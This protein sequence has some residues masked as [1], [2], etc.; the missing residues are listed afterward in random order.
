MVVFRVRGVPIRV[1]WSWLVI[2]ALVY[3]SL[4]TVLFPTSYE[5]LATWVYLVMAAVATVLL[6]AS[7]LVHEL[8]HTLQSLREGVRIKDITL[9]LFGGVSQADE[10]IP[11]PGAEFRIVAAGPAASAVLMVL[12]G[13]LAFAGNAAGLSDPSVGVLS[14]LARINGLLLV[15]NVIPALPL[16]GGRLLHALLWWRTGDHERATLLAAWSGRIF[17]IL[18]ISLGA[19]FLALGDTVG[20]VWFAAIGW[21]LYQAVGQEVAAAR[22]TQAF[23]GLHVRDLMTAPPVTLAPEMTIAELAERLDA[24]HDHSA[25]PVVAGGRYVGTLMLSHAGAV[26]ESRRRSVRVVDVMTPAE[27][28]AVLHPDDEVVDAAQTLGASVRS[29]ADVPMSSVVLGG[30]SGDEPVGVLSTAD[31]ERAIAAAPLRSSQRQS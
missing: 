27:L 31:L 18:I 25:Y 19:V 11:G 29:G 14:Y 17:A 20:G 5:G 22:A 30:E 28:V 15:F 2:V 26:P 24:L 10:P 8:C 6:F 7:L 16:D 13:I 1:G 23:T 21:F 12:F 4:S 9:F 3:W